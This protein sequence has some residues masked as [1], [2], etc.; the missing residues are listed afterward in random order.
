MVKYSYDVHRLIDYS[1]EE[2]LVMPPETISFLLS[3]GSG[4]CGL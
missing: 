2:P 3:L 1:P 4:K